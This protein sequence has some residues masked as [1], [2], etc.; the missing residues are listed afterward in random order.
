M[1]GIMIM[2][3]NFLMVHKKINLRK[4]SSA[5]GD[6]L[7]LIEPQ[8]APRATRRGRRP[9]LLKSAPQPQPQPGYAALPQPIHINLSLNCPLANVPGP[10]R[11]KNRTS[12]IRSGSPIH[13]APQEPHGT[14]L[15]PPQSYPSAPPTTDTGCPQTRSK[16]GHDTVQ[17]LP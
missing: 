2:L 9:F 15:V 4:N 6:L 12:M 17:I 7:T 1:L 10:L 8:M 3:L 5:T 11:S 16:P 13:E 14:Q